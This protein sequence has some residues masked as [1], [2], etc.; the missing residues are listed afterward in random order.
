MRSRAAWK[1]IAVAAALVYIVYF[2]FSWNQSH[3]VL[4]LLGKSSLMTPLKRLLMPPWLYVRGM[5]VIAFSFVR[6]MFILGKGYP[7]GKWFY[8]PA[9]LSLKLTLGS[10]VI[11]ATALLLA[12]ADRGNAQL[13]SA[14]PEGRTEI[15][16]SYGSPLWPF[17]A[18]TC[19]Q[20][21]TSACGI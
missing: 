3:D 5:A 14:I 15:G 16:A 20:C 8:F 1:G 9:L 17:S 10:I 6:P 18:S 19:S 11:A 12:L 21:S 4:Y 7:H 13:E 2:V